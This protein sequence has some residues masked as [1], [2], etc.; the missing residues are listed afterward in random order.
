MA[1]ENDQKAMILERVGAIWKGIMAGM[2]EGMPRPLMNFWSLGPGLLLDTAIDYVGIE[3]GHGN[4]AYD[5]HEYRR[6]YGLYADNAFQQ[7]M[8]NLDKAMDAGIGDYSIMGYKGF[9]LSTINEMRRGFYHH[10]MANAHNNYIET[11]QKYTGDSQELGAFD[12]FFATSMAFEVFGSSS[13]WQLNIESSEEW[14]EQRLVQGIEG[15]MP[16]NLMTQLNMP[17]DELRYAA[18][19]PKLLKTEDFGWH[20]NGYERT[21][22]NFAQTEGITFRDAE[23]MRKYM[24]RFH[25][26]KDYALGKQITGY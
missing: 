7:I 15:Q 19:R 10:Q 25:T 24:G 11:S 17:T 14:L 16:K 26:F 13:C 18:Y 5:A 9:P 21:R 4:S 3:T 22:A 1:S 6:R 12:R 23:Q 20:G 2:S 8:D